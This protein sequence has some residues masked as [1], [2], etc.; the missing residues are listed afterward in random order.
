LLVSGRT[1]NNLLSRN[2]LLTGASA[3]AACEAG[4]PFQAMPRLVMEGFPVP[5]VVYFS[6]SEM[7]N[8]L[9]KPLPI[10]LP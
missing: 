6:G 3:G 8:G 10:T 7:P 9:K 1:R 5:A 2:L 4:M